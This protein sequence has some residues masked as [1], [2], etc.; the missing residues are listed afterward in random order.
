[1]SATSYACGVT[2]NQHVKNEARCLVSFPFPSKVNVE[3]AS[4]LFFPDRIL[5]NEAILSPLG[6]VIYGRILGQ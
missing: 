5:K 4:S 3:E 6:V 1:V 2:R